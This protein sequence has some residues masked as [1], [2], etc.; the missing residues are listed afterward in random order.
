VSDYFQRFQVCCW[1]VLSHS[2]YE[3]AVFSRPNRRDEFAPVQYTNFVLNIHGI[4]LIVY[5][6][7]HMCK[8][9]KMTTLPNTAA[10]GHVLLQ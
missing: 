1:C 10:R 9:L 6:T 8:L 7:L 5:A 3:W 2:V 4:Y